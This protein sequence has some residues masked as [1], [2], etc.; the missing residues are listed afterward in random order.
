[1]K[2]HAFAVILLPLFLLLAACGGSYDY[3]KHLSEVKRD[4]FFAETEAFTLTLSCIEREHPYASDGICCPLTRLMEAVLVPKEKEEA[5]YSVFLEGD[6]W[7]GEMSRR[8]V[9]DDWFYAESVHSFPEKQ[10][11][12]RLERDGEIVEISATSV[13]NEHTMSAEEALEI[14][15]GHE[16]EAIGRLTEGGVFQGEFR[17]RLL[18]RNVNYYYVGIVS[19]SGATISL[20]LGAESGEVLARRE[21]T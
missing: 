3:T 18:R 10:V 11:S 1:M 5:A 2:K 14:A 7:G 9:E 8:S 16:K 21:T 19:K 17:V 15:V 20:L 6:A 13:K 4:V 12:I